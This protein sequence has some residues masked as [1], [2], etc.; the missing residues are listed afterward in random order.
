MTI[1]QVQDGAGNPGEGTDGKLQH[2]KSI[3]GN[4]LSKQYLAGAQ[5]A[6]VVQ[7]TF[8]WD[9]DP[10]AL[11]LMNYDGDQRDEALVDNVVELEFEYFGE[12]RPP[13]FT[14]TP[15]GDR[16]TNYGPKPPLLT[17]TYGMGYAPG[18]NC[19]FMVDPGSGT[20]VARPEMMDLAPGSQQL[21]RLTPAMLT[22]GPWCPTAAFP[23]RF[24]ADL[25]RVRKI[26]VRLRVQVA[27]AELRGPAALLLGGR[28]AFLNAGTASVG[29]NLVPDQDIRF[30][31]TPRNLN[32]GR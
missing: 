24:D 7:R 9:D 3:V 16:V 17:E 20:Q 1:T 28:P 30:E 27:S 19:I 15:A 10:N 13:I 22:D 14:I 26:G 8:Y 25:F 4:T 6:Q 21:V 32:M 18:E 11:R 12:P 29:R 31:V 23:T 5:V 2:N